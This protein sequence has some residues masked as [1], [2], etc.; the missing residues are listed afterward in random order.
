[1]DYNRKVQ[2]YKNLDWLWN[3]RH[4]RKIKQFS[5]LDTIIIDDTLEK[6]KQHPNNAIALPEYD[7]AL[8]ESQ[9]DNALH[10]ITNYLAGLRLSSNVSNYI[11]TSRLQFDAAISASSENLLETNLGMNQPE[12]VEALIM[13]KSSTKSDSPSAE[14][15]LEKYASNLSKNEKRAIR[16]SLAKA[17]T[18][19]AEARET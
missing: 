12:Q 10:L 6:T 5:Q 16:R 13:A 8:H 14:K 18:E 7:Q 17:Q 15:P 4:L 1:M 19:N 2:T 3:N 9:C 11:A